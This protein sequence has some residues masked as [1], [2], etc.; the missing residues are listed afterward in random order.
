MRIEK[1][2][3]K[4]TRKGLNNKGE[5]WNCFRTNKDRMIPNT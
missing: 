2:K 1:N 5:K 4:Q 3:M